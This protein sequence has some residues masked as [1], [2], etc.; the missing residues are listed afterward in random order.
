[1][2]KC[3]E[4]YIDAFKWISSYESGSV[5]NQTVSPAYL[6]YILHI[7]QP[8]RVKLP[9]YSTCN[10]FLLLFWIKLCIWDKN[11]LAILNCE[12]TSPPYPTH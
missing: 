10:K 2:R 5:R 9:S 8:C 1:M 4:S 12:F 3:G 7:F 6:C 11:V